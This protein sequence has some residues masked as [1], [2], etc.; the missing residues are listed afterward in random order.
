M[1]AKTFSDHVCPFPYL[2]YTT[3]WIIDKESMQLE[4]PFSFIYI[5]QTIINQ[6]GEHFLLNST[7]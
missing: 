4:W 2:D 6:V 5:S 1:F 7:R 3:F